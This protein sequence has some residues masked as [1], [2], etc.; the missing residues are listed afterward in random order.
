[1]PILREDL[2]AG[3]VALD[4]P[5]EADAEPVPPIHPG[6][7]LLTEW[8]DPLGLAPDRVAADL[9]VTPDRIAALLHGES[10]IDVDLALRLARYFGTDAQSWMTLQVR[11]DLETA[12]RTLAERVAREVKPHAA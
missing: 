11:Y 1:M 9:A 6:E 8:L 10:A 3:R 5:D 4:R 7:L 12:E 2:D